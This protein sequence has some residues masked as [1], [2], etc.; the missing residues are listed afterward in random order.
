MDP[1]GR[2]EIDYY[3]FEQ[4]NRKYRDEGNLKRLQTLIN[5]SLD[6]YSEI[7]KINEQIGEL[8]N[9]I[10]QGVIQYVTQ[11]GEDV[12]NFFAICGNSFSIALQQAYDLNSFLGF[13]LCNIDI[14]S[15]AETVAS[16]DEETRITESS[17]RILYYNNK[18][19]VKRLEKKIK[20]LGVIL[21]NTNKEIE[22]IRKELNGEKEYWESE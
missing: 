4:I 18:Q 22:R 10:L 16:Y 21:Y 6:L 13:F 15:L 1:D 19:E 17:L 20:V 7:G 11:S 14:Q 12:L 9:Q 2:S 5:E 8:N 3:T